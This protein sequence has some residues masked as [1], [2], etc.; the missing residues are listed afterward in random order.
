[1]AGPRG[2]PRVLV[3]RPGRSARIGA[4]IPFPLFRSRQVPNSPAF[5][6]PL[7][8]NPL[9]TRADLERALNALFA[10]LLPF[11]SESG[12]RVRLSAEAAHFDR[13]AGE[14]EGYARPLW[15][16]AP[17]VAGGGSFSHWQLY[18]N[19]LIAGTD[20]G[21]PD[22]WG[23]ITGIDQRQVEMAAIG[24]TLALCREHYWDPLPADAK[25]RVAAYLMNARDREFVD[26]NWKFFRVLI[27][28]GLMECG[29]AVD[30]VK[31]EDYLE[32]I[33][34]FYLGNG[35]YRDG[36]I[37]TAEHYI[38][39][40][41]HFYGLLY[42]TLSGDARRAALYRERARP[43][44]EAMRHWHAE[45][46]SG[47]PF[48]RSLTYRFAHAGFWA[49]LAY[50]GVEALPWGEIKGYYLRNMRWW[51]G[52]PIADRDGVLSIGYAYPNL[53]MS[54]GYNS[55]GSPYWA[56]K[57][58]LPLALPEDH[59][60]WQ[61][62]ETAPPV[63]EAPVP[64]AEPGMVAQ[65]QHG[66]IVVLASG[67]QSRQWRGMV[68]KYSKFAYSTCYGFSIEYGDREFE[69]LASDNMLSFSEDGDHWRMRESNED[70]RIAGD[71]LF[72][73]WHPY[74]DVRVESFILPMGRWHIRL[75]E[76]TTP[77]PIEVL[78]GGF[79][80]AKPDFNRFTETLTDTR[81][82]VATDEDAS[83]VIGGDTRTPRVIS[84]FPNTN[85]MSARTLVPQLR[86]RIAAGTTLL[87]C[88]VLAEPLAGSAPLPAEPD[89]PD[90]DALRKL[91]AEQ[92]RVVP[93][94]D[95]A[96]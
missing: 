63:F 27:D 28:L 66:H 37:R 71:T 80:I 73:R 43:F 29:V 40:A 9:Q 81:A 41:F 89:W 4:T 55:A 67:Q 22:Y 23:D 10:P 16:I 84:P 85:L 49:A 32:G 51:A 47:L 95:I 68:E 35:W 44:A 70:V 94:F 3:A 60:F 17:L 36:N 13:A 50:A 30:P 79:A 5:K 91:F 54:E 7:S 26:S 86:G 78:E 42:A 74:P 69:K 53:M 90:I 34:R 21:H 58:F 62:E 57:A 83:V 46:G 76:V 14:L 15:G 12:A 8:G 92:G 11:F 56:M 75:H 2:L 39:F 59:P 48:G 38:P 87:R 93:V 25:T 64:L 18:R 31:R 1:M 45:D 77:R 19:G 82:E 88:A 33:E 72:A 20:P 65:H 52:Q 96:L 61:A 6:T 24:F